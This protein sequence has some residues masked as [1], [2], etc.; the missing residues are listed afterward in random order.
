M[1]LLAVVFVAFLLGSFPTGVVLG[2]LAG[3]DVR[4]LGSGNIGAAN[5]ARALGLTAGAAVAL[6][7]ILKGLIPVLLALHFGLGHMAAA[8]AGLMAVLGHD[9]S[10]FLWL[11][12][13]KGVATTFGVALALAPLAGVCALVVWGLVLWFTGYSSLGS[14]LALALLPVFMAI[15]SQ[16]P[17]YVILAIILLLLGA[18]KHWDN[19][20][21]LARGTERSFW[22][23]RPAD[24][25]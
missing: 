6:V 11:R 18:Y 22:Q 9:Y 12:G 13:G 25:S 1:G 14:L 21:R 20:I 4:K 5:V 2:Y 23:G 7:D 3:R 15:T 24:G 16:P 8:L 19:I 17:V 10:V